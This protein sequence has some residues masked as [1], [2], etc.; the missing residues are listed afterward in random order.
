MTVLLPKYSTEIT[1]R[2]KE[3]KYTERMMSHPTNNDVGAEINEKL[4]ITKVTT[5]SSSTTA[6]NTTGVLG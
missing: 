4:I 2:T 3:M 6:T 5:T 1:H